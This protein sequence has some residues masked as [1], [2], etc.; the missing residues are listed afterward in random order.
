MEAELR[1]RAEGAAIERLRL[2]RPAAR[3]L[4]TAPGYLD[5]WQDNL[6]EGVTLA[7]FEDDLRRGD[8]GELVDGPTGPAKFRAAFSSCALAVNTFGP[9]RRQPEK[10]TLAGVTGFELVEFEYPCENGLIGTKLN[11]D[12]FARTTATVIAVESKFLEPLRRP[13]RF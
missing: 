4:A 7:D 6:I 10:L 8:D 3:F 12:L 1:R 5:D 11:F 9:F 13:P 2:A